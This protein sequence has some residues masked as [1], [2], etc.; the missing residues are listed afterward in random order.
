MWLWRWVGGGEC[1][2]WAV[3]VVFGGG[4][5]VE[6]VGEAHEHVEEG[7]IV[8]GFGDLRFAPACV[9]QRLN[10]GVGDAVGVA[11]DGGDEVEQEPL[12][13][14]DGGVVEVGVADGPGDGCEVFA[15]QLQEPCVVAE[16][17]VAVGESGDVGGDHFVLGAGERA[18]GEVEARGLED[19][20]HEVWTLAHGAH[21]VG[22][23][24]GWGGV[25]HAGVEVGEGSGGV[26]VVYPADARHGGAPFVDLSLLVCVGLAW[27]SRVGDA[28]LGGDGG[29]ARGD[30]RSLVG[31]AWRRGRVGWRRGGG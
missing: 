3:G 13:G 26:V 18:I 30:C 28:L 4:V 7:G 8:D 24:A 23:A 2:G 17:V 12:G 14:G 6:G 9:A 1:C 11:G 16:S 25:A 29:R 19:G 27:M 15:L 5:D 20:V 22:N 21:D 31:R 10:L